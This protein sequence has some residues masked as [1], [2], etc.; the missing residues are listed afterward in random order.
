MSLVIWAGISIFANPIARLVGCDGEGIVIAVSCICIP[1]E[2]FS[3]IQMALF[4]RDL[5][6]KT[7]FWVRIIEN[8]LMKCSLNF[9]NSLVF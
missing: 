8:S 5:D 3:S 4:R 9:R 7:L 2:A 1:V 6:F